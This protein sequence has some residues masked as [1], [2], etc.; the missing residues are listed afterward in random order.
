MAFAA[1][2]NVFDLDAPFQILLNLLLELQ[3]QKKPSMVAACKGDPT[4]LKGK[5]RRR[6]STH[7]QAFAAIRTSFFAIRH[8]QR[9]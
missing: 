1:V 2:Q 5:E 9:W 7:P 6:V 4:P 8:R 3:G